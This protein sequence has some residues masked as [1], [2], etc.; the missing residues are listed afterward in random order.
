MTFKAKVEE[1]SLHGEDDTSRHYRD[2]H[3]LRVNCKEATGGGRYAA[4]PL[5]ELGIDGYDCSA[6]HLDMH[7]SSLHDGEFFYMSRADALA[8]IETLTAI[9]DH[10]ESFEAATGS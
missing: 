8:A 7:R 2:D 10:L 5:L 4:R 6:A 1:F 3:D 9:R